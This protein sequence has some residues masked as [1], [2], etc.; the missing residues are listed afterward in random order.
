MDMYFCSK[1]MFWFLYNQ[2][3]W[4]KDVNYFMYTALKTADKLMIFHPIFTKFSWNALVR[5]TITSGFSPDVYFFFVGQLR[6]FWMFSVARKKNACPEKAGRTVTLAIVHTY[7]ENF[8]FGAKQTKNYPRLL[9]IVDFYISDCLNY[10]LMMWQA[11]QI[12]L[13]SSWD[14]KAVLKEEQTTNVLLITSQFTQK[15]W[16]TTKF[17]RQHRVQREK[18]F[19]LVLQREK[20]FFLTIFNLQKV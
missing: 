15:F 2:E 7:F 10:R 11:N 13:L 18:I 12:A 19:G 9:F 16:C 1:E 17:W 3:I 5:V 14:T 8:S 6:T 4:Y 20:W